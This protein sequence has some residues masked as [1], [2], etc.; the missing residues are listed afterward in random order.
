MKTDSRCRHVA[1]IDQG[2][3]LIEM[4]VALMLSSLLMTVLLGVT[5]RTM[6]VRQTSHALAD[7]MPD[8]TR[9]MRQL[10]DDLL[11]SR[12]MHRLPTGFLLFGPIERD[13]LT[14]KRTHR[15]G[16]VLYRVSK[17]F[18]WPGIAT[19]T[20]PWLVRESLT[21][22]TRTGALVRT[23]I[24]PIWN[25]IAAV[26]VSSDFMDAF[27]LSGFDTEELLASEPTEL[28]AIPP[29]V[30]VT[31]VDDMSNVIADR[32]FFHHREG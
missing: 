6:V 32:T 29:S 19:S 9:M 14:L 22:D 26:S 24:E 30:R 15:A 23:S 10:E 18:N 2:L 17:S 3:T 4:I 12:S 20:R 11:Q 28:G 7:R 13:P 5:R 16:Y 8:V 31:L 25:G 1:S 21:R 27:D